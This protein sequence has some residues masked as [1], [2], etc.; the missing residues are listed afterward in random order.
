MFTS[1]KMHFK[2]LEMVTILKISMISANHFEMAVVTL[3]SYISLELMLQT[4]IHIQVKNGLVRPKNV[5]FFNL[6]A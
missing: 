3:R 2:G 5:S 4:L 6:L 1:Y